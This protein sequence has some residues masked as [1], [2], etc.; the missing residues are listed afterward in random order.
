ML[1]LS[2]G[3][4]AHLHQDDAEPRLPS[5]LRR[6]LC[7]K[8]ERFLPESRLSALWAR[9]QQLLGNLL[10]NSAAAAGDQGFRC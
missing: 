3:P 6:A 9:D 2:L 8:G 10:T 4:F 1:V 7:P 5:C